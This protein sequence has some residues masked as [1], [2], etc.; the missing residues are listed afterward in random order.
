MTHQCIFCGLH[1]VHEVELR[2]G[3]VECKCYDCGETYL[4][5]EITN[6]LE[7]R[8]WNRNCDCDI[9]VDIREL[10]LRGD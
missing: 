8:N 5:T 3:D 4:V 9:C 7:T 6:V 1:N 2:D 10:K